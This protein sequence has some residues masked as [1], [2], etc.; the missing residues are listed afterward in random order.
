MH[1]HQG[2]SW[3]RSVAAVLSAS[4]WRVWWTSFVLFALLG[5]LWTFANPPFAA[6][7]EPAHVIHAVALDHGQLTGN[8]VSRRR[9]RELRLTD[10][11]DYLIVRV[12]EIYGRASDSLCFLHRQYVTAEC[13]RFNGSK[14]DTDEGTYVARHPPG[15]YA[16][17][18]AVSLFG[19]PGSGTVYAM[20]IV[21][22]LLSSALVA[23]AIAALRRSPAPRLLAAGL[24]I[25][26]T[27]MV[28]F[29]ASTVNPSAPEIA[30]SLAFWVC[31]LLLVRCARERIDNWLVTAAGVA[32]CVLALSRQLGP[33]WIA[34]SVLTMLGV[35]NRAALYNLARSTKARLWALFIA[36]SCVTQVGWDLLVKPLDVSRSGNRPGNEAMTEIVRLTLGQ[37]GIRYREMI[38]W[39]GWLD[40]PAPALTWIAWTIVL[41]LILFAAVLW[42]TRSQVA[43][44]LGLVAATIVVPVAIESATFSD[45]G[46]FTWQGRYTLPLAVGVPILA[47]HV[48]SLTERGRELATTRF[49]VVVGVVAV[50]GHVLAFGQNLR[51]YTVGYDGP[52]Q[53]WKDAKWLPPLSPLVLLV[54]FS[55]VVTIFICWLLV[56]MPRWQNTG[57]EGAGNTTDLELE[58]MSVVVPTSSPE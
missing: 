25:A 34:F 26:I 58:A 7:D 35:T 32:G 10:R 41:G 47:T 17:V 22:V 15:Y 3:F 48:L 21:S 57:Q 19:V 5:G 42:A 30:S 43:L 27:P 52:I 46:T 44:L 14:R 45:A 50:G 36:A 23:T 54:V 51:R 49:F 31:G 28:L 13:L 12:P 18:G 16:L 1:A 24:A 6:P 33:L 56:M 11:Q 2:V 37:T 9:L 20:R 4:T 8:E 40:T 38:G 53:F 29:V 39:F 55:V